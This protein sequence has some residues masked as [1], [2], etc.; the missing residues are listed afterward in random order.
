[1][2]NLSRVSVFLAC[3][4][5]FSLF[6]IKTLAD[7]YPS[8]VI[9][10]IAWMGTKISD[11]ESKNWWRYEWFELYNNTS[12]PIS[13]DNWT[14]ELYRQEMDWSLPL[15]G[16]IQPNNYFL[17]V[18]SDKISPDYDLNYSNL[19]G[20]FVN[21]G[22]KLILKDGTGNIVDS[23]DCFTPQKWFAGDNNTK[24]TMERINSQAES[25]NFQNWAISK[26]S[27]GTPRLINSATPQKNEPAEIEKP[28]PTN[29]P[30]S[31]YPSNIFINEI[32]PSPKGTDEKE[33][34][35]EIFNDN[36]KEV[37]L[38]NWELTDI[39]GKTSAYTFPETTT[40]KPSGFL[41]LS[42]KITGVVL[43]NGEDGLNLIQ[44]NGAVA[45]SVSYKNAPINQ[46][47]NKQK[48]DG[49]GVPF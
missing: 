34:W 7:S 38:Y 40:I 13:I 29:G 36:D 6:S 49:L 12:Q 14:F 27:G 48:M 39:E 5:M 3:S 16:T 44:P 11:V 2:N 35:I 20:K 26:N 25:N 9:N 19:A 22:Q 30:V 28:T 18:S 33:E 41:V 43:N 24:Q 46:S 21:S 45:D 23:V 8:A 10:E 31:I 1:M 47:Y 15:H 17:V 4:A 37:N 32:L 42:R